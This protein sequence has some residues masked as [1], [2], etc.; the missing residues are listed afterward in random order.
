MN[1]VKW[2]YERT[3]DIF[4]GPSKILMVAWVFVL[5]VVSVMF[6]AVVF[7][8][9]GFEEW[10]WEMVGAATVVSVGGFVV[11]VLVFGEEPV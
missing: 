6:F 3:L 10:L 9:I 4:Q 1:V 7:T 8:G 2:L 5:G 11:S